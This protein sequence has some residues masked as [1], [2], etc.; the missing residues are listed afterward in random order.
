[1]LEVGF[2]AMLATKSCPVDIPPDI[3]PEL[4]DLTHTALALIVML[5]YQIIKKHKELIVSHNFYQNPINTTVSTFERCASHNN[6]K[7]K[8]EDISWQ[9]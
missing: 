3:P 7:E 5:E 1:M 8:K 2:K 4:L 6:I 9:H